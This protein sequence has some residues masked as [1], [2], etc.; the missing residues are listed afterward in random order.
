MKN[1][2]GA[3]PLRASLSLPQPLHLHSYW[4]RAH[5]LLII[6]VASGARTCTYCMLHA[7]RMHATAK[8][9]MTEPYPGRSAQV[10]MTDFD[11]TQR[12]RGDGGL[13]GSG[14]GAEVV[15]AGESA[16]VLARTCSW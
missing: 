16:L 10:E 6:L 7:Q 15:K 13:A 4:G 5:A 11:S 12:T 14:W 8:T 1:L 9:R 2:S 3:F